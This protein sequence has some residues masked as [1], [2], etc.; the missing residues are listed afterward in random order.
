M[1]AVKRAVKSFG[2]SICKFF[3]L[4]LY[5]FSVIMYNVRYVNY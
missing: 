5:I 2:Q 4:A 1:K 3:L